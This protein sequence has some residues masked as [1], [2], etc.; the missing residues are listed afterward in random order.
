MSKVTDRNSVLMKSIF[1][2]YT[3]RNKHMKNFEEIKTLITHQLS[4]GNTVHMP[5]LNSDFILIKQGNTNN[6]NIYSIKFKK[7]V[8]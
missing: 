3:K 1:H 6:I 5:K 8:R 7:V 4:I 2:R